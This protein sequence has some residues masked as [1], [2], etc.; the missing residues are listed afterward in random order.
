MK[1]LIV[2]LCLLLCG[3][4]RQTTPVSPEPP[5]EVTGV[6]TTAGLYDPDHPM[7]QNHPGL[8][9]VY[10]LPPGKIQNIYAFGKDVLV[11]SGYGNTRMTLYTGDDLREIAAVMWTKRFVRHSRNYGQRPC[12]MPNQPTRW[13]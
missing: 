2:L 7:E 13:K 4:A 5:P 1:K 12:C 11:L 6:S 10:P 8:V 3:C 9:R